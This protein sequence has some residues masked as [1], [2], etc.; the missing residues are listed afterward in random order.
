MVG[1]AVR[2]SVASTRRVARRS[3]AGCQRRAVA[4]DR[5]VRPVVRGHLSNVR[6]GD[7]GR[8]S[9]ASLSD[10]V[11]TASAAAGAGVACRGRSRDRTADRRVATIAER[12]RGRRTYRSVGGRRSRSARRRS[13]PASTVARFHR[14][15]VGRP[16]STTMPSMPP[17]GASMSSSC[18]AACNHFLD[19]CCAC[20]SST[21][22][23][24]RR[25]PRSSA[26][27]RCRC[28]EYFASRSA[29]CAAR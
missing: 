16:R 29:T 11:A 9:A 5:S 7:D 28:R 4:G 2:S 19:G 13:E 1:I 15:A 18:S 8:S 14:R 24:R 10:C 17:S 26:P 25:S 6:L 22:S 27:A 12:G 3:H 23:P 21:A 20:G